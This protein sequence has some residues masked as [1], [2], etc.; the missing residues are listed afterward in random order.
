MRLAA[1]KVHGA[2]REFISAS[3]ATTAKFMKFVVNEAWMS[4]IELLPDDNSS[5]KCALQ[6]DVEADVLKDY[7]VLG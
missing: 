3:I 5:H 7:E 1:E 2:F 4:L 6:L